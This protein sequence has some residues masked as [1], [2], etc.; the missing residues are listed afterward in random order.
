MARKPRDT[1]KRQG[2]VGAF[3]TAL[4]EL[5]EFESQ[6]ELARAIGVAGPEMSAYAG[7]TTEAGGYYVLRMMRAAVLAKDGDVLLQALMRSWPREELRE[8][9]AK[10]GATGDRVQALL[11]Q[12]DQLQARQ[13]RH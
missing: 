2:D 11:D 12:Q 5:G 9:A 6:A 3:V 13:E 10:A 8:L 7:G 1:Q 4:I